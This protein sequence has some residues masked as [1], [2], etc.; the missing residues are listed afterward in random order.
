MKE[1]T[2]QLRPEGR[3]TKKD[4]IVLEE[5]R[6]GP[7][8]KK[9]AAR[10]PTA[11][12]SHTPASKGSQ[13]GHKCKRCGRER[14]AADKCMCPAKTATCH[15]CNRK[16]HYSSQCF[17]KT[18]GGTAHEVSLDSAFL[19]AVTSNPPTAW[20]VSLL[21]GGKKAAFKL[22][23][24]AEV[25]VISEDTRLVAWGDGPNHTSGAAVLCLRKRSSNQD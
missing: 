3:G 12:G 2:V 13:T 18:D 24:G 1:Q 9:G 11:K 23:T 14:H 10:F 25:T 21:V 22:D 7:P 5:V 15:K 8:Y 4:P 20:T 17:S 19:G 16:G 6:R